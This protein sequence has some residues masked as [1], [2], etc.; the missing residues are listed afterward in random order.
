M[1]AFYKLKLSFAQGDRLDR[2]WQMV[3]TGHFI[4]IKFYR[5]IITEKLRL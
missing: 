2:T 5:G 1:Q 4:P 3:L